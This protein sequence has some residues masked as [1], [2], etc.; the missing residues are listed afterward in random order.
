MRSRLFPIG[1][2]A[3]LLACG[4]GQQP[5]AENVAAPAAKPLEPTPVLNAAEPEEPP[6][7]AAPADPPDDYPG[8]AELSAS[9]RRAYERGWRD[10]REGRYEP[11][12]W[13]EAYRIGCA[14]AQ[15]ES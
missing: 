2:T 6:R 12:E 4:Q 5:A 3:L 10:C 13:A 7:P 11:G 8:V 15:E 1:A 9:Q 14:A